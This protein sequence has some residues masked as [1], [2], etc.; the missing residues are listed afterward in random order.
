MRGTIKFIGDIESPTWDKPWDAE[1]GVAY[2]SENGPVYYTGN[3]IETTN[4]LQ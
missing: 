2:H 4:D 1:L 3:G